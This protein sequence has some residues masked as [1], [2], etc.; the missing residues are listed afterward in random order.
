MKTTQIPV[1]ERK[2]AQ[3]RI[4]GHSQQDIAEN[5][6]VAQSTISRA[7]KRDSIRALIEKTYDEIANLSPWVAEVY[8]KE[9]AVDAKTVP[10]RRLRLEVADRIASITGISPVRDSRTSVLL[11]QVFHQNVVHISPVVREL[12]D[13]HVGELIG[14]APADGDVIDAVDGDQ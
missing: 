4:S 7:L 12:L 1:N 5:L 3:E 10:E 6:G 11:S 9:I 13:K 14:S 8:G 2:I